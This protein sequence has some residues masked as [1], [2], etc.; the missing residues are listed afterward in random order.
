MNFINLTITYSISLVLS[1]VLIS[2]GGASKI[3][4]VPPVNENSLF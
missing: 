2:E 3:Y 4:P 1:L